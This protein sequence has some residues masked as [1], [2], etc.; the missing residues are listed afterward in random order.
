MI[1]AQWHDMTWEMS[2][3]RVRAL[4]SLSTSIGLDIE[5]N[6]DSE[7][8]PPT[9]VVRR[10]LQTLDIEYTVNAATGVD[11]RSE[12][13][14]W[15]NRVTAGIHAPFYLGGQQFCACD[16]LLTE[17][18]FAPPIINA[19]GRVVEASISVKFEE[20]S[21]DPSGLKA[22]KGQTVNLTP[23]IQDYYGTERDNTLR[24]TASE[25]D[26]SRLRIVMGG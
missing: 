4:T 13:G 2:M 22:D 8:A 15:W 5:K 18:S 11:P 1:Q 9:Q 17:A 7:G 24:I 12:Y 26:R 21:E 3:E 23:G 20:Y 19:D 16:Y 6:D 25:A 14:A 10:K